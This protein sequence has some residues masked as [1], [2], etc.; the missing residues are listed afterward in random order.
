MPKISKLC[1]FFLTFFPFFSNAVEDY[2]E[3][4]EIILPKENQ[5]SRN[6]L[7]KE[8]QKVFDKILQDPNSE[9]A[10]AIKKAEAKDKIKIL[11]ARLRATN[12]NIKM[13]TIY[14]DINNFSKLNDS[15]IRIDSPISPNIFLKKTVI[16]NDVT[17]VV[18][19]DKV[20][21]PS[22]TKVKLAPGGIYGFALNLNNV[23]ADKEKVKLYF[24]FEKV[25][26]IAVDGIVLND[27]E[28]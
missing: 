18:S 13:T 8:E 22:E 6:S 16:E 21:I 19:V 7:T 27:P 25:G 10:Q 12:G 24:T 20:M 26:V 2:F 11:N 23:L 1:I 9:E 15:L 3:N 28:S 17:R 14:V 4:I 5:K